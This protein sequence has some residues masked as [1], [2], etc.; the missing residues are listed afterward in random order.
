MSVC[1]IR[2]YVTRVYVVRAWIREC[3]LTYV[4]MYVCMYVH[5]IIYIVI[6]FNCYVICKETN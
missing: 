4:C 2:M 3:V 1:Q 6:L 5:V